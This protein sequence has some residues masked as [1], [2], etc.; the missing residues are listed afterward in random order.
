[1]GGLIRQFR[2]WLFS[3]PRSSP[4]TY[5]NPDLHPI[6]TDRL[7]KEL[8]VE[9]D[10]ERLG[11]AEIPR[12]EA[13]APTGTESSI[14]QRIELARHEYAAWG[15][16]RAR[17]LNGI[18][19]STDVTTVADRALQV[20]SEFERKAGLLI[21][22]WSSA[23]GQQTGEIR[24]RKKEFNEF[25]ET[26]VLTRAARFPTQAE[27]VFLQMVLAALVLVEGG[28]NSYFFAQGMLGGFI[29]GL[30]Y[31]LLFAFINILLAYCYGRFFLPQLFHRGFVHK[32]LG[33]LLLTLGLVAIVAVALI[34]AHYRLAVSDGFLEAAAVI[35][36]GTFRTSP[37][38]KLQDI[39]SVLLV[40]VSIG[41]ALGAMFD[42]FKLDD[43]YPGYGDVTRRLNQALEDYAL[44]LE[45][46]REQREEL[47][48]TSLNELD[49]LIDHMRVALHQL[50]QAI[51]QK[52]ETGHRLDNAFANANNCL[53]ALLNRFRQHNNM[54][55]RTQAPTY[56]SRRVRPPPI[57]R[58]DC[59][60]DDDRA[61]YAEQ[62]KKLQVVEENAPL[63][64]ANIQSSYSRMF[65]RLKPIDEH[66]VEAGGQLR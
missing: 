46:V 44:E 11:K 45:I 36:W 12:T 15:T 47:K 17:L 58:P 29:D 31:A 62:R 28:L 32:A 19:T 25:R 54:H 10:A 48:A 26:H 49:K 13:T 22:E 30:F 35:A 3:G 55:R 65:D 59:N 37:F 9:R 50:D 42:A 33:A 1:M 8:N 20:A 57:T 66:F 6:D 34:I 63:I 51:A 53:D 27:K 24:E 60:V 5:G 16:Q 38:D 23:L 40:V 43:R 56:F 4:T 61:K 52:E 64:R 14:I 21:D 7:A 18:I 2:V 41:F 39:Q